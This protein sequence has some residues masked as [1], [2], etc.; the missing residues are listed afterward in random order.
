MKLILV[1]ADIVK[2]HKAVKETINLFFIIKYIRANL[3]KRVSNAYFFNEKY[4]IRDEIV[5]GSREA[6]GRM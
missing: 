3:H 2:E 1:W 6:L 4:R 5:E